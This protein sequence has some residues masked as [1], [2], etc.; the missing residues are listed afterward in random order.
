MKKSRRRPVPSP[1]PPPAPAFDWRDAVAVAW[2][3][4]V[5][6]V[7]VRQLLEALGPR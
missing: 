3:T 5:L 1:A 2:S 6:V 4:G 7:F